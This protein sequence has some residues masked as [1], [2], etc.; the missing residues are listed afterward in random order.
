MGTLA[1]RVPSWMATW[2][3]EPVSRGRSRSIQGRSTSFW[4]SSLFSSARMAASRRSRSL[5]AF[6]AW[7]ALSARSSLR[8]SPSGTPGLGSSSPFGLGLLLVG[9]GQSAR[10]RTGEGGPHRVLLVRL[11]L[12]D[13]HT[14]HVLELS[15][16]FLPVA[17]HAH[18]A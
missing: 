12:D 14:A 9:G 8:K 18:H 13:L 2:G 17:G 15:E 7:R 16:Q 11:R 1:G 6:A 4:A 5:T 3:V 10:V